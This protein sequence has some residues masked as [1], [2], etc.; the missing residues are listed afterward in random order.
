MVFEEKSVSNTVKR[1]AQIIAEE[2]IN[3]AKATTISRI[4]GER[5]SEGEF[6]QNVSGFDIGIDAINVKFLVYFLN[7]SESDIKFYNSISHN[8]YSDFE[9]REIFISTYFF[10]KSVPT[11][12]YESLYHE[13]T[14]LYQ[15]ARGGDKDEMLY[16]KIMAVHPDTEDAV[17]A[18]TLYYTFRSEQDAFTHQFYISLMKN[19]PWESIDTCINNFPYY[20]DFVS[21]YKKL[22][23]PLKANE[24][25][26]LLK[27]YELTMGGFK[28]RCLKAEKR[29]RLKLTHAYQKYI[30]DSGL[31]VR[32]DLIQGLTEEKI[33]VESNGMD[34]ALGIESI[35]R[36][37]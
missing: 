6:K 30:N 3:R 28:R 12:L 24:L 11:D 31:N 9:K 21:L 10:G 25:K 34:F 15:I 27:K 33:K 37:I 19:K 26:G 23:N 22:L 5:F 18:R 14:H 36:N 35:F 20:K 1:L 13:L 7:Y 32:K 2:I 8:C 4:T 17:I 16:N 29:W